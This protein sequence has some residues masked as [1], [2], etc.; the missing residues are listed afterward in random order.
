MG[1]FAHNHL[2]RSGLLNHDSGD[3]RDWIVCQ[4]PIVRTAYCNSLTCTGDTTGV[5]YVEKWNANR[6]SVECPSCHHILY[7]EEK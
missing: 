2:L 4:Q 6:N 1:Y 3:L 7:W 5:K